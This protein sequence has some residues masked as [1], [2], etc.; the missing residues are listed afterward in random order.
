MNPVPLLTHRPAPHGLYVVEVVLVAVVPPSFVVVLS[1]VV[2]VSLGSHAARGPWGAEKL[3]RTGSLR[4]AITRSAPADPTI[5]RVIEDATPSS[6]DTLGAP[7][8]P[9]LGVAA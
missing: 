6:V 7:A 9:M 1:Y 5:P 8:S 3:S 2:V 4:F